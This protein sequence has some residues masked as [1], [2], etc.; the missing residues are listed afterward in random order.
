MRRVLLAVAVGSV[1]ACANEVTA[2]TVQPV[3]ESSVTAVDGSGMGRS[4]PGRRGFGMSGA[5]F[6]TRRLPDNLKLSDSQRAQI[7]SLVS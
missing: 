5:L 4:G 3:P 2:P 7:T 6:A 1:A